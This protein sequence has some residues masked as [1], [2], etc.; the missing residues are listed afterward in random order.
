MKRFFLFLLFSS[1]IPAAAL[2]QQPDTAEGFYSRGVERL[3][4]NNLDGALADL[5]K[6]IE[7][8][9]DYADAFFARSLAWDMKERA[10]KFPESIKARDTSMADLNKAVALDPDRAL[11]RKR[12]GVYM[13]RFAAG[14]EDYEAIIADFSKAITLDSNDAQLYSLRSTIRI[15]VNDFKGAL[16]DDDRAV[17]LEPANAGYV[18]SRGWL[19]LVY[20]GDYAGAEADADR[21]IKLGWDTYLYEA[22]ATRGKARMALGRRAQAEQDFRKCRQLDHR[23]ERTLEN[24]DALM[25][26]AKPRLKQD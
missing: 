8:R 1:L 9:P 15:K 21:A 2:A 23:C 10:S 5:G 11:F 25:A 24:L 18:N 19:K 14:P 17:S 6:A 3:Q 13:L 12:R 22:Y 20:L 7:M 26:K 16:E 4:R